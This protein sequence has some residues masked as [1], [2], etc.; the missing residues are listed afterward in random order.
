MAASRRS[1]LGRR[2]HHSFALTLSILAALQWTAMPLVAAAQPSAPH[3]PTEK[4]L[5]ERLTGVKADP[6]RGYQQ[7]SVEE[8]QSSTRGGIAWIKRMLAKLHLTPAR[9]CV[10]LGGLGTLWT[11]GKN[12]RMVKWA[13]LAVFSW[14]LTI[15]GICAMVFDWPYLN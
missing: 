8:A 3:T 4:E 10:V 15:V 7:R 1:R 9:L 5:D 14:L 13:V 2:E 12:K 11:A 6:L